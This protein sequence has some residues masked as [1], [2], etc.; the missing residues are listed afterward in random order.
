MIEA[1]LAV[2]GAIVSVIGGVANAGSAKFAAKS[3][4]YEANIQFQRDKEL[5]LYGVYQSQQQ[6]RNMVLMAGVILII[7]LAFVAAYSNKK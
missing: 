3:A 2:I 1:I 5:S 4:E 7:G 6:A